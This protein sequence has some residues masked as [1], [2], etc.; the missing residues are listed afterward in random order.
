MVIPLQGAT[1]LRGPIPTELNPQFV[2][3]KYSTLVMM[4]SFFVR[5]LYDAICL[6]VQV[7]TVSGSEQN[8]RQTCTPEVRPQMCMDLWTDMN[9]LFNVMIAIWLL[10]DDP[11]IKWTYDFLSTHCC[12]SCGQN[13]PGS[14]SCLMLFCVINLVQVVL[15][16]VR[17]PFE[18]SEWMYFY[19]YCKGLPG[20]TSNDFTIRDKLMML[21]FFLYITSYV[22]LHLGMLLGTIFGFQAYSKALELGLG[23]DPMLGG[24]FDGPLLGGA[25]NLQTRTAP[26]F[27]PDQAQNNPSYRPPNAPASR[28]PQQQRF[29]PFSG[30]GYSLAD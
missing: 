1:Q 5:F 21:C 23:Q 19:V 27:R 2:Y 24:E 25:N 7:V 4:I 18:N 22:T 3:I 11:A 29:V 14:M 13:C 17:I 20:I 10:K 15:A 6:I 9:L 8:E 12:Y 26:N 28:A 16:A 30:Q